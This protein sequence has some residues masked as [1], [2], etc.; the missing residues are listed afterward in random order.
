MVSEIKKPSVALVLFLLIFGAQLVSAQEALPG[1]RVRAGVVGGIH[2]IAAGINGAA[3]RVTKLFPDRSGV[4][5]DSTQITPGVRFLANTSFTDVAARLYVEPIVL[6][7]VAFEAGIRTFYTG[8]ELGFVPLDGYDD[9]LPAA[10]GDDVDRNNEIG[11]F[12]TVQPRIK[13]AIGPLLATSSLNATY[14]DFTDTEA[15]HTEEPITVTAIASSDWV[16][17]STSR[18]L[19]PIDVAS[20]TVPFLALGVEY[21]ASWVP[22]APSDDTGPNHRVS[23]MGVVVLALTD[24]V[25][26]ESAL[27]LG[28]YVADQPFAREELFILGVANVVWRAQ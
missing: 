16:L 4:L 21:N 3:D 7:D 10:G 25:S 28:S 15:S 9:R 20:G 13:F 27:F 19:Y 8:A 14:Y 2:P 17:T 24:S 6:F 12:G 23:A 22:A 1:W 26:L 18:F 11:F 5:W